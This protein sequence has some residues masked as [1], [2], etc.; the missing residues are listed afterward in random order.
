MSTFKVEVVPVELG[1]HPNADSLSIANVYSYPVVVRTEDWVGKRQA[2]YVPVDALVPNKPPFDFLFDGSE[3]TEYRIKAKKLRGVF[4][5]G[6]LVP[7]PEGARVGDD[8]AA[9]FGVQKYEPTI[10]NSFA[11][12]AVP[13]PTGVFA[14]EYTGIEHLRKFYSVFSPGEYVFLTEKVHGGNCRLTMV[15]GVLH[16]GSHR[17]WKLEHP[18]SHWWQA[19][20]PAVRRFMEML[21]ERTVAYG[22]VYGGV[23]D[24]RYGLGNSVKFC[25]FDILCSGGRYMDWADVQQKYGGLVDTAPLLYEGPFNLAKVMEVAERDSVLGGKGHAME[26]VVVRPLHERYSDEIGRVI[27]KLHSQRFLLRKHA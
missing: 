27:L 8:L 24:L 18:K 6:L 25:L 11:S 15:D 22:E 14:P 16:V 12:D 9:Y 13:P 20:T 17:Q 19:A 2:A 1:S 5:Q 10:P 3:K 26:G 7:A 4:S 21:P 23:Q